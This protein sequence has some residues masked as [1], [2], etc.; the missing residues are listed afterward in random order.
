ME[1]CNEDQ[2]SFKN[3][4]LMPPDMFDELLAREGPMITQQNTN[5]REALDPGLKLAL[6]LRHLAPGTKYH[7]MAYGW[8]VL[9]NTMSLLI[10]EVCQFFIDEYNDEV[11][12]CPATPEE[13]CVISDKCMHVEVEIRPYLHAVH[14]MASTSTASVFQTVVPCTIAI[15]GSTPLYSW[16]SSMLIT[17]SPVQTSAIWDQHQM[18][19]P[20]MPQS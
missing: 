9:H 16:R 2:A 11:M 5:Y 10:P 14:L 8:R 6:T 7:S 13:W 1:L 20:T 15:K 19:R 18:L 12:K 4:I 3:V 17:N